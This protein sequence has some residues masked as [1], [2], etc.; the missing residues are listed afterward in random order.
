[1]PKKPNAP[2]AAAGSKTRKNAPRRKEQEGKANGGRPGPPFPIVGIGASAGGLE[3]FT[4]LLNG[5]SV[6]C[7]LALVFIQ[8]LAPTHESMLTELLARSTKLPVVEVRNGMPIE[9][10]HVYVIPPNTVMV[11]KGG[12]L[13]LKPRAEVRGQQM[14]V[15]SFFRSMAGELKSRGIGV[16]LSGTGS[17]GTLGLRAIKAEGGLTFAQD[18][19]SAKYEGMPL[20]A[21]HAGAVDFVLPPQRIAQELLRIARNPAVAFPQAVKG[22][23][24]Q[25]KE[26]SGLDTIFKLL[27]GATGI[28]FTHYKPSTIQRRITRRMT[29][30]KLD[31][32]A[33]YVT[34]L[35]RSR[36]EVDALYHD[37]LINVTSF[38]RDP[39]TFAAIKEKVLPHLLGERPKD[40]PVRIWVP[41][42][43]TGEEAYS[44][45]ITLTEYLQETGSKVPVQIFATDVSDLVLDQ[46]RNGVFPENISAD[47][48]AELLCSYFVKTDGGYRIA[49][50]VRDL[51]VFARQDI[52][53]DPPFSNL[54]LISCRNLLIYMDQEMQRKIIPTFHF[55]LKPTGVLVLGSS[56]SIGGF[57]DL[58]RLMDS[59]NKI[60]LKKS[61]P[62]RASLE[63]TGFAPEKPALTGRRGMTVAQGGQFDAEKEAD[64]LVLARYGPVGVLVN[65]NFD[66]IQFRGQTGKYLEPAAGT[67]TLNLLKMAR[68]GLFVPLRGALTRARQENAPVRTQGVKVKAN[69]GWLTANLEVVPVKPAPTAAASSFLVLFERGEAAAAEQAEA[70]VEAAASPPDE[71]RDEELERLRQELAATREYL[72]SNVAAQQATNEE[73]HAALEELQAANEELQSTNEEMETTKEELQSTNEELT[74]V[75]EELE[76]RNSELTTVNNDLVNLLGSANIPIVMLGNDL[77][78]RRFT[79]MAEKALNLIPTDVGRPFTDFRSK[80]E[81]DDLEGLL[82]EVLDTLTIRELEVQDKNGGWYSL[83]LRPYRTL[84]NRIEG[85]VLTLVEIG[86]LKRSLRLAEEQR[87]YAEAIVATVREPLIVLDGD[88]RVRTANSSFYRTFRVVPEETEGRFVF[89]LGGG[90]WD[91]PQL[92]ELLEEILPRD[93]RLENY[94]VTVDFPAVGRRRMI[95]NARTIPAGEERPQLILLAMEK[96]KESS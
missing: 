79:P 82:H 18:E 51:C 17:D 62:R 7:G 90:A 95:L 4:E 34:F 49:K 58:F 59:R 73:L 54:D 65:D 22:A 87:D 93:T 60:Y 74:T 41:A 80:L 63:L 1:M 27:R 55:A 29:V 2:V 23:E 10:N 85:L 8:H 25:P 84:E 53:R 92:R 45:G 5:L 86:A 91:I 9:V 11:I 3:A 33:D 24:L 28:D 71:H 12:S 57:A 72:Q 6:D 50:P 78:I 44:L 66:I 32:L 89:E 69:G 21:V 48:P 94:E 75:N 47:V 46:A 81:I 64:R 56:E 35:A 20:S 16:V 77:R 70:P 31:Q 19:K 40:A 14:P 39:D 88:L 61:V 36:T 76:N 37:M 38:F 26:R 68:E 52:T 42:C 15:D 67:A 96:A 13:N 43:S 30:N 83:R